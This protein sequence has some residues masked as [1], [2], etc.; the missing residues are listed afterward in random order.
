MGIPNLLTL[1]GEGE[2]PNAHTDLR[3]I[4]WRHVVVRVA[5]KYGIDV[6]GLRPMNDLKTQWGSEHVD[7][8]APNLEWMQ[9]QTTAQFVYDE[10]RY[11]VDQTIESLLDCVGT[12]LRQL[13]R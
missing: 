3:N 4:Y 11:Y 7:F 6:T 8:I 9:E 13:V 1:I 2:D 5:G 10:S 12:E